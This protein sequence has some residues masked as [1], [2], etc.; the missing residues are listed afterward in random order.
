[1]L[2]VS[3]KLR[4]K[5]SASFNVIGRSSSIVSEP[6]SFLTILNNGLS[7]GLV[8]RSDI[9]SSVNIFLTSGLTRI[10]PTMRSLNDFGIGPASL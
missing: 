5:S 10:M 4:L 6:S 8:N 1:M 7:P 9:K 2:A 3:C